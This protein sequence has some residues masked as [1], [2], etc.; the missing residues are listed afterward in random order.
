MLIYMHHFFVK[1]QY[2]SL[3]KIILFQI[4]KCFPNI[5]VQASPLFEA[6]LKHF[7]TYLRLTLAS[8]R[9]LLPHTVW[10][11]SGCLSER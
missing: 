3:I 5:F 6:S 7:K 2:I 1:P 4:Y 11:D 10:G 8:Q 9:G